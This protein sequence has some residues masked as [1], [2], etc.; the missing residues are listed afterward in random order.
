MRI[1]IL[2]F[3][4][5]TA[6]CQL[7]RDL[8][9]RPLMLGGVCIL[10]AMAAGLIRRWPIAA[11]LLCCLI[12][13]ASGFCLAVWRADLRLQERLPTSLERQDILIEGRIT[14]LPQRTERGVRFLFDPVSGDLAP[15]IRGRLSLNWYADS[16]E[17]LPLLR[18]GDSWRLRVRL[19]QAHGNF[20]PPGFDQEAWFLERGISATGYVR[21]SADNRRV[22]PGSASVM[23]WVDRWREQIRSRFERVLPDPV[24]RGVL[25]A[26]VVGDQAAIPDSQWT[27]FRMTG[28][29]H[30]MSISG[31]HVTLIAVLAGA[32][33][34][35]LW[36]RFP[37]LMLRLPAQKAAL[38]AGVIAAG[39]YVL[40][41]GAGVPALRTFCM[42]S[43]AALA[44]LAGRDASPSRVMAAALFCVLLI[45]PWAVLSAG[46]WLSFAAVG[47]L[48]LMDFVGR[49]KTRETRWRRRALDWL[50]AQWAVSVVALPLLLGLFQ[51]FS[52]VSPL[53]NAIAIPAVSVLITPLA[54]LFA[55]LPLPFL[56]TLAAWLST[57]LLKFL[58]LLAALPM[59]LWQ[60]AA[61]PSW[62]VACCLLMAVLALLP[63]GMPGRYTG[64]LAF[65]PLV[66]F[67]PPRPEPGEV[68]VN[69]L[70]VGQGL[71]VHVQTHQRD[72]LFDTGPQ[73]AADSD[74][75]ARI[76]LPWLRAQGVERIDDLVISHADKDHA[77]GAASLLAALPVG[78]LR[79]SLAESDALRQTPVAHESCETGQGWEADG[80]SFRF[81]HPATDFPG[82]TNDRSCVLRVSSAHGSV[83]LTGDIGLRA[84]RLLL[85]GGAALQSDVLVAP[86][87]GSRTS[88]GADFIQAVAARHVV[89]TPGYLSRF[90]HPAPDVVARYRESGARLYRSDLDGLIRFRFDEAGVHAERSRQTHLRYWH[91]QD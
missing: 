49:R 26:L 50:R 8:P 90:G 86:H 30:L 62:L 89:F 48:L 47:A 54:M 87:H 64:L 84:E 65:I 16:R 58:S 10:I 36:R 4:C 28:T 74:A 13:L 12:A 88:S 3:A 41:A 22:I 56:A 29:T 68:F 34:A 33:S 57:W 19:K 6:L 18:S 80:V 9:S 44:L 61:P 37:R 40:I 17:P 1:L 31:L 52:L 66:C 63:R 20:N 46:F 60:Q 42:L 81:L 70:D 43:V 91:D 79:S 5:G 14:D 55:L 78:R 59:A 53:A 21:R 11:R 71:S 85:D 24:A 82:N 72:L 77:G 73:Y 45:D 25:V 69:V 75:G 39:F 76:V 7:L 2:C 83:L 32:M 35:W 51:Q 67:L 38:P 27:L 15:A 23:S